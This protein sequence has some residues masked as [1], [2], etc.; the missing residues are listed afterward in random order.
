MILAIWE[1]TSHRQMLD[2]LEVIE[3]KNGHRLLL[4]HLRGKASD[5]ALRAMEARVDRQLGLD[6]IEREGTLEDLFDDLASFTANALLNR[7]G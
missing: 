2:G 4:Q 6:E 5:S 1:G 3:R 7:Q